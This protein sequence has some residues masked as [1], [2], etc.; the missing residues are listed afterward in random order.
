MSPGH[1]AL[2]VTGKRVTTLE[3]E[4]RPRRS[5][6]DQLWLDDIDTSEV[7]LFFQKQRCRVV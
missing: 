3:E 2:D 5:H 6:R 4:I 7:D 1:E